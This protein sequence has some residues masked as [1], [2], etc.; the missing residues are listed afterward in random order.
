MLYYVTNSIPFWGMSLHRQARSVQPWRPMAQA[1]R[2][3]RS[4]GS[5]MAPAHASSVGRS[6]VLSLKARQECGRCAEPNKPFQPW[7][8]EMSE[9]AIS[10]TLD[11]P[12]KGLFCEEE[13]KEKTYGLRA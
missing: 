1:A 13:R 11:S 9:P 3:G 8:G 5:V 4:V 12:V 2:C 10:D 7:R 6:A